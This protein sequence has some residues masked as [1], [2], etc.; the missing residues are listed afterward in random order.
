MSESTL[1]AGLKKLGLSDKAAAVV[2][3]HGKAESGNETNR[4]QGDFSTGRA[5]SIYYTTQVDNGTISRTEFT[6][7]GPNGGGYGWLQW[8]FYSRKEGL[9]DTAKALGVSIGSEEAALAWFWNE[10]HQ[11]E[12]AAVLAALTGGGSI[13][14]ISDVFMKRFERPADQSE[15]ACSLRASFAEAYYQQYAGKPV[16]PSQEPQ[17]D[18]QE[19]PEADT[20]STPFWPPRV[21][22]DG[23]QGADVAV[24]Q[25][26]VQARG[27]NC[28]GIN[29]VFNNKTK[30]MVF[31][32]Q[33]EN[34][35]ASDGI[36]GPKTFRLLGVSV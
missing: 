15:A 17:E 29:G 35:L 31:A 11:G 19:P 6:R 22:C 25:A 30:T 32:F 8:T 23:M 24:L 33:A 4:L 13:R 2:M 5:T 28:G 27:Y 1:W 18:A 34:G 20:P 3:G 12:Y 16:E 10:L 9:Y 36:A 21:L 7:R 14:E 26:H